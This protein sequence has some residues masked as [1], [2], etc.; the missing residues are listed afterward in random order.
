MQQERQ[1]ILRLLAEGKITPEEAADLLDA[2]EVRP[3]RD[4]P[5]KSHST[6]A[7]E[8]AEGV[9]GF[10]GRVASWGTEFGARV[11]EEIREGRVPVLRWLSDCFDGRESLTE[12]TGRFEQDEVEVECL[13]EAG[14]FS[15]RGGDDP[16]YHLAVRQR[17]GHADGPVI[18]ESGSRL[19]VRGNGIVRGDLV[20]PRDKRYRIRLRSS[21]GRLEL[22]GL[23]LAEGVVSTE[24]GSIRLN[25]LVAETL[26][27]DSSAGSIEGS[28][29]AAGDLRAETH[30]GRLSLDLAPRS[31]G[32]CRVETDVGA[33]YLSLPADP[34][35][36]Y[37]LRAQASVGKIH[38]SQGFVIGE[39]IR[40]AGSRRLV[41]ES[42]QMAEKQSRVEIE[43]RTECGSIRIETRPV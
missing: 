3:E 19:M 21:A 20:L 35:L 14:S 4:G 16:D 34:D 18:A 42:P 30:C 37:R 29:L 2:V 40:S 5:R 22:S 38:C 27:A 25:D 26:T 39:D 7:D 17:F 8:F 31:S 43:A 24:A 6:P 9:A 41:A 15:L 28:G 33:I 36:G 10:A 1:T 12:R 23:T 11:A 13:C 32:F